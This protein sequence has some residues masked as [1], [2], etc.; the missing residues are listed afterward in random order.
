MKCEQSVYIE[1][2]SSN[3]IPME[4]KKYKCRMCQ[5]KFIRNF[6]PTL[7]PYCGRASIVVDEQC[8][9]RTTEKEVAVKVR[10]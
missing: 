4:R 7:C 8:V 9:S 6:T 1:P 5:W 3:A 10:R 2:I